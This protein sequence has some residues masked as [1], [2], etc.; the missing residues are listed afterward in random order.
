MAIEI[1]QADPARSEI[2]FKLRHLVLATIGGVARRW[3]A[4]LRIDPDEPARSA[5]DVAID[6]ASLDT[7]DPQRDGHIRSSEFLNVGTHPRIRFNSTAVVPEGN[8]RYI[9]RGLLTILGITREV[10]LEVEDLD[11]TAAVDGIRRAVFRAHTTFDR[12]TFRLRWNQ[13]LDEGGVVVGDKVEV[14]IKVE[15]VLL[16]P[17]P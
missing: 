15:A 16:T 10:V 3:E 8:D 9:V 12:Q 2:A 4:T 6:A 17:S 5:I 14:S 11:R 7:G 13:D 1:W